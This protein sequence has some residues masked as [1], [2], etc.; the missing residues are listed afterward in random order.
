MEKSGELYTMPGAGRPARHKHWEDKVDGQRP[1]RGTEID[2]QRWPDI[3]KR[4]SIDVKMIANNQNRYVLEIRS[5]RNAIYTSHQAAAPNPSFHPDS[6]PSVLLIR[7]PRSSPCFHSCFH[8]CFH[9]DFSP[10]STRRSPPCSSPS[11]L[12]SRP[13]CR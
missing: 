9:P 11:S 1:T 10:S 7:Y 4:S 8:S 12:A 6:V 5:P 13:R 3:V 2:M